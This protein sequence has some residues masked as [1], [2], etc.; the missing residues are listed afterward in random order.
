MHR[1]LVALERQGVLAAFGQ[2]KATRYHL[3]LEGWGPSPPVGS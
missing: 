1:D 3:A 2:G